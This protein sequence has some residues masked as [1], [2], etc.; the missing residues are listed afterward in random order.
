[1]AQVIPK[2]MKFYENPEKELEKAFKEY[3]DRF[4][5][6][7][8]DRMMPLVDPLNPDPVADMKAIQKL[9]KAVK[10]GRRLP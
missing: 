9:R 10:T 3:E 1:M 4:G 7:S 2:G 6:G 5:K 8:V